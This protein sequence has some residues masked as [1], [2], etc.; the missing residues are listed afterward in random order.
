[1]G[2]GQT[3]T[4]GGETG[5][6]NTD[7]NLRAKA[8]FGVFAFHTEGNNYGNTATTGSQKP[9]FMYNQKVEWNSVSSYW[10]YSPV[11]YWPNE[12]S[13]TNAGG[14]IS[15]NA[16]GKVSFFAYAPW[17]ASAGD[18]HGIIG[19]STNDAATDP[20]ITYKLPDVPTEANSVDLLWG[21]RGTAT[22]N[23]VIGDNAGTVGSGYNVNLTKQKTTETV[24][25]LFKHA[26]AKFGGSTASEKGGIWIALDIDDVRSGSSFENG[27]SGTAPYAWD[28]QTLVTVKSIKIEDAGEAEGKIYQQGKFDIATGTWLDGQFTNEFTSFDQ[29]DNYNDASTKLNSAIAE[30][31]TTPTYDAASTHKWTNPTPGVTA[32][33]QQIYTNRDAFY[34]IPTNAAMK[35]KI[36]VEYVV[37]TYDANL[38]NSASGGEGTWTKVT[39]KITKTVEF[40]SPGF[41]PHHNYRLNIYLGMTTMK[42]TATVAAW[43]DDDGATEDDV[44]VGVDLPLNVAP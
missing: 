42:L 33:L 20:I 24:D 19:F 37:R 11:K 2:K 27:Q 16:H 39:Q 5:V 7:A 26:L 10:Q 12:I 41:L 15:E 31:S 43:G 6:T 23:E 25:F 28:D 40:P 4:V 38:N 3:R 29:T 9:N 14:A 36:T 17:I 34:F 21:T 1:M 30:P 18:D 8:G 13:T 22:Y 44:K 32:T 35:F